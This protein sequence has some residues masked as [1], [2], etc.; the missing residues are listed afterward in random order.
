MFDIEE[1][2]KKVPTNS[3]VYLMFD[4]DDIVIYIGKAKVL[5]NRLRQYFRDSSKQNSIKTLSMVKKIKRFEYIITNTEVEALILENNLIKKYDPKYNIRLK[6]DKTYPYVKITTNEMFPKVF[7]TRKHNNDKAKYFGPFTNSLMLKESIELIHNIL[8][9]RS[10]NLKF[11]RDLGKNRPCLNYHIGKCLAPCNYHITE[12]EYNKIISQAIDFFNG[13]HNEII[14]FLEK[15]MTTFSENLEFEKAM[16]IRDKIFAIKKL[17]QNQLVENSNIDDKDVIAFVKANYEAMVQIFFVR[18]GKIIG[19]EQFLLNNVEHMSRSELM[20]NFIKQFYSGTPFIPKEIILQEEITDKETIEQWL[21]S[22]KE[23]KVYITTP[24]K[25]EK[26]KLVEMAYQNAL[27]SFER[28]G[29][30]LKK[31]QEKT[32]GALKE[33]SKALGIKKYLKRIEAYDISNTQGIESVGSMVVFEDGKPL[34]T[35]YRKFKIKYVVGPNDYASMQ[36]IIKR[37]FLRYIKENDNNIKNSFKKMP[38]IIFLD[39]GKGQISA[40][41]EILTEL[42][43]NVLICGMV[44]DDNHKTR[45]LLFNNK[46]IELKKSSEAFKLITRIQDEVHRFSIEFHRKSR[47]KTVIKSVLDNIEGIGEKRKK[48]LLKHFGSIDKIKNASIDELLEVDT[49]SKKTSEAVYNFFRKS[50]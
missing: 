44:K 49:M 26:H 29:D 20:E 15:Q 34:K 22:I 23:Q 18:N 19:R 33:I 45:G 2:L 11:P 9:I 37:R 30:R 8:P 14:T 32:V 13:K 25:G 21:S 17:E 47:E 38:D 24:K 7:I 35:D 36:E 4:K 50:L 5:K 40:V 43:I 1:E 42:N 27:I 28:F 48:A 10:C 39:G 12:E 31:E 3:G 41:F 46:E 16:E 6:D